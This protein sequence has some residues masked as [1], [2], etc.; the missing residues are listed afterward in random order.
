[1]SITIT[2]QPEKIHPA[3][4]D[5]VIGVTS[6]KVISKFKFKYV[7]DLF[8]RQ[9][10]TNTYTFVG[11]VKQTPNP[12]LAG[13][14]DLSKYLQLQLEQD[15][16]LN[17]NKPFYNILTTG[18]T[19]IGDY[20]VNCGE[21]YA[22]SPTGTITL[23]NGNGTPVSGEYLTGLTTDI[24]TVYNGVQQFSEGYTYNPT[25]K[26]LSGSTIGY[27]SSQPLV[28]ER[29]GGEY[30]FLNAF[31]G[32]NA[33]ENS[34]IYYNPLRY[35]V[36]CV[37]PTG[38]TSF[39]TSNNQSFVG[40]QKNIIMGSVCLNDLIG[41]IPDW[42]YC[43]LYL[44]SGTTQITQTLKVKN[45]GCN[46]NKYNPV[47]VMWMNRYGTWDTFRFY[48]SKDEE[49][50]IKRKTYERAYGT[51]DKTTYSYKTTERG[52]NNIQTDLDF[53]GKIMSDFLNQDVVNWLEELITSPQVYIINRT[54]VDA[55]SANDTLTPINIT[56]NAFKRQVKGNV[57]LRQVEFTYTKSAEVRTQQF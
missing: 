34:Y 56:S 7:F 50:K 15:I 38:T 36:E 26:W 19:S 37:S 32:Q 42:S 14:L 23:Y 25:D 54:N 1:M 3:Y 20:Y 33:A 55:S 45:K 4:K 40:T 6:D 39:Y 21:E 12:S 30:V 13:L 17:N 49:L 27:L 29:S 5:E 10:K 28:Q 8:F 2:Q 31:Q 44:A 46:W 47:D 53:D 52:T 51:W 24:A 9:R 48:G 22:D 57:K 11:R 41:S 35:Y 18:Q 43:N 16:A